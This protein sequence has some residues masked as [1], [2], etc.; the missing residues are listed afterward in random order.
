MP[1]LDIILTDEIYFDGVDLPSCYELKNPQKYINGGNFIHYNTKTEYAQIK[2]FD[3]DAAIINWG[4]KIVEVSFINS[5]TK[6]EETF[7]PTFYVITDNKFLPKKLQTDM[8]EYQEHLVHLINPEDKSSIF[9]LQLIDE[10][11]YDELSIDEKDGYDM[12]FLWISYQM[13]K[14][15]A[16]SSYCDKNGMKLLILSDDGEVE[17][18]NFKKRRYH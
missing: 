9:G 16:M 18:E 4:L 1:N 14:F 12:H 11:D 8:Q 15:E 17:F 5:F 2:K 13:N 7:K 10:E 3:E 6:K